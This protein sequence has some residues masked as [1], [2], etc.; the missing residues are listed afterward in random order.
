[1]YLQA[2]RLAETTAKGVS[3]YELAA[4]QARSF[5]AA[6]NAM[7]LVEKRNAWMSV[8]GVHASA[9]RVSEAM[10]GANGRD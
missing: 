8:P 4:M 6:I 1:M 2:R 5:L 7:A 10:S 9:L 3:G